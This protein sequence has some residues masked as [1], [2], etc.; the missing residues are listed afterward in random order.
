MAKQLTRLRRAS[1]LDRESLL[2]RMETP[3]QASELLWG[4]FRDGRWGENDDCRELELLVRFPQA[5]GVDDLVG[6]AG[7]ATVRPRGHAV[8]DWSAT[9]ECALN[10]AWMVDSHT[11]AQ[12]ELP[13][14]ARQQLEC[15]RAMHGEPEA[16]SDETMDVL[17][18]AF[19]R[20]TRTYGD[21]LSSVHTKLPSDRLARALLRVLSHAPME[22]WQLVEEL[23]E[24]L[25][26]A[27]KV[28]FAVRYVGPDRR[29]RGFDL[30]QELPDAIP[31]LRNELG[32]ERP[33]IPDSYSTV[34]L[35]APWREAAY[36]LA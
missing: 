12:S 5:A 31:V 21:W 1:P 16:V 27:E 7:R 2:G 15:V 13:V 3:E 4:A 25:S 6:L 30:V 23:S 35:N 29:R 26:T 33:I 22:R 36:L 14:V 20:P 8:A 9:T 19:T 34:L 10:L 11:V 18:V 28:A 32:R 17:A 24:H